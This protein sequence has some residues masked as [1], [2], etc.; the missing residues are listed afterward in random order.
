MGGEWPTESVPLPRKLTS[1]NSLIHSTCL[2]NGQTEIK[3]KRVNLNKEKTKVLSNIPYR[4]VEKNRLK[5]WFF[6]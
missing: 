1:K 4:F 3:C 2:S 6:G 5:Q